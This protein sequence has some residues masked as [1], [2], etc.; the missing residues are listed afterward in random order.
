MALCLGFVFLLM[1]NELFT[2]KTDYVCSGCM[3]EEQ[4]N[5]VGELFSYCTV[6][7]Q[8]LQSSLVNKEKW[9]L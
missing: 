3:Q 2:S 8:V 9:N 7:S 5:Y 6:L 1:C 4:K